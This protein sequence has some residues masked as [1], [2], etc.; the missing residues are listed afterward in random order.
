LPDTIERLTRQ[1]VDEMI[2]ELQNRRERKLYLPTTL[3][4][5]EELEAFKQGF[6]PAAHLEF[7]LALI[8]QYVIEG[9]ECA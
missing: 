7:Y 1:R 9:E 2:N 4:S 3:R 6:Y 5:E 8:E